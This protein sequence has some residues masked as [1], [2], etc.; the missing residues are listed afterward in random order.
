MSTSR[1]GKIC[2]TPPKCLRNERR[3]NYYSRCSIVVAG[4]MS[5][6]RCVFRCESETTLFGLPKEDTTRNQWLSYI[7]NTVP[8]HFNTNIRVCEAQDFFLILEENS[9]QCEHYEWLWTLSGAIPTSQGQSAASDSQPVSTFRYLKNLL[10]TIQ[11]RVLSC[12]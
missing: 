6:R 5:W 2:K 10:L 7:Y 11:T 1:C 4:A 3:W 9:L 12:V 8:E